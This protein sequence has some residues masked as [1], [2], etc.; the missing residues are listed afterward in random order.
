MLQLLRHNGVQTYMLSRGIAESE[1]MSQRITEAA[2]PI[3]H[4]DSS[5]YLLSSASEALPAN[6]SL[7]ATA[8]EVT[9]AR[10]N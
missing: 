1:I 8:R 10:C 5:P 7:L 2:F 9:L 4:V 3:L 6:C